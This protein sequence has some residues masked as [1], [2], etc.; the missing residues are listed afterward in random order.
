M[1]LCLAQETTL[2]HYSVAAFGKGI[3]DSRFTGLL[4]CLWAVLC[5]VCWI[6]W[7]LS[8]TFCWY[9]SSALWRH[10]QRKLVHDLRCQPVISLWHCVDSSEWS[11]TSLQLVSLHGGYFAKDRLQHGGCCMSW[12]LLTESLGNSLRLN[13]PS[14]PHWH[15]GLSCPSMP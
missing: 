9:S 1:Y 8:V 7:Q 2:T 11:V 13:S 3:E 12:E 5:P 10:P 4:V 14:F 15:L 6:W